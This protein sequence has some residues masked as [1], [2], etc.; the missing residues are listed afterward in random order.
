MFYWRNSPAA[1]AYHISKEKIGK[2]LCGVKQTSMSVHSEQ[3]PSA[4]ATC[5]HCAHGGK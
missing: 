3:A 1:Q 2:A 4:D 5:I